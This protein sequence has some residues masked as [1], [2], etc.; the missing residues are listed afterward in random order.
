MQRV[1]AGS[2][3]PVKPFPSTGRAGAA[4]SAEGGRARGAGLGAAPRLQACAGGVEHPESDRASSLAPLTGRLVL[5]LA[6]GLPAF[7]VI[8]SL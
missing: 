1:A 2:W 6:K 4:G 3:H 5:V 7:S 8:K